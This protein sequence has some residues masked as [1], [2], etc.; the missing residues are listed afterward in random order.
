MA[1]DT[2]LKDEIDAEFE[3]FR[4]KVDAISDEAAQKA[5]ML[6]RVELRTLTEMFP[7]HVIEF[8][9][10]MYA[11]YIFVTPEIGGMDKIHEFD[12]KKDGNPGMHDIAETPEMQRM[13]ECI[14][15]MSEIA[16]HLE[17]RYRVDLSLV[18]L[19]D[20]LDNENELPTPG[21]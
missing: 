2:A 5:E 7:K 3:E 12:I 15:K 10:G 6:I 16:V 19:E 1:R 9:T 14:E 11:P 18:A 8:R 17:D 21:M 4:L 20:D 13:K